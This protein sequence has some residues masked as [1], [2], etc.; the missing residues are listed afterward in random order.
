MYLCRL[1]PAA[2][3]SFTQ[4][5]ALYLMG[6]AVTGSLGELLLAV[7]QLTQL[8]QL[9]FR[10]PRDSLRLCSADALRLPPPPAATLTA[11]TASTNLHVLQLSCWM[12]CKGCDRAVCCSELAPPTRTCVTLT[13]RLTQ[14]SGLDVIGASQ[15][16]C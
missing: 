4:V 9:C 2:I 15:R 1:Q 13:C 14:T 7:S 10:G 5:R 8:T 16:L 6:V 12:E 11:L 3:A